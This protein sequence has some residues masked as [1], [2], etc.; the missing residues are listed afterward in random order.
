LQKLPQNLDRDAI[1]QDFEKLRQQQ[2]VVSKKVL[3][4]ILQKHSTFSE[5]FARLEQECSSRT[6]ITVLILM[7]NIMHRTDHTFLFIAA[8]QIPFMFIVKYCFSKTH[9]ASRN[10]L[11]LVK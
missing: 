8:Q 2:V 11:G 3:Q 6:V 5:E 7:Y 10:F 9:L 1:E 4:L